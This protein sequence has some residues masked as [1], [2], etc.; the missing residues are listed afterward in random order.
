MSCRTVV[1]VGVLSVLVLSLAGCV[2]E[3]KTAKGG[4]V[5]LS[6]SATL[7][8]WKIIGGEGKF[9]FEDGAIVGET[10]EHTKSTYLCSEKEYNDFVIEVE[11]KVDP[12]LN[13]GIQIRGKI[14]DKDFT[15]D[16]VDGNMK[17]S[18]RTFKAGEIYGYQI[19]IDPSERSW[20]GGFYEQGGRGWIKNL[21]DN[22][23]A[24]K[25]FKQNEWNKLKIQVVGNEFVTWLNGVKAIEL[26]D[27]AIGEGFI[28]LQLHEVYKPED[29]GKKVYW[30]NM[31]IREINAD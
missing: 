15:A 8:G 9:Y 16:Y 12:A 30:R 24:K 5:K 19:D 29:A 17:R 10:V 13:S 20:T 25:A 22:E 31:R 18:E 27:D 7:E 3:N 11:F 2:D 1:V 6:D 26:K 23:S 4:W 21:E 14:H 28:G